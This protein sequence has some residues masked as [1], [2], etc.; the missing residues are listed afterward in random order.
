MLNFDMKKIILIP[1]LPEKTDFYMTF[2]N[3]HSMIVLKHL[4]SCKIA[5]YSHIIYYSA[6]AENTPSNRY[7]TY[8]SHYVMSSTVD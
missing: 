7:K 5:L 6:I 1:N 2:I 4:H 8:L 3:I